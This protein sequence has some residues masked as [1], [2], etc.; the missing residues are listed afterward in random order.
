MKK[1]AIAS[2]AVLA[3][4]ILSGCVGQQPA[5]TPTATPAATTAAA[6]TAAATTAAATTPAATTAAATTAAP[7][8]AYSTSDCTLLNADDIKGVLGFDVKEITD[9]PSATYKTESGCTKTW[10]I[11]SKP[12]LTVWIKVTDT[13]KDRLYGGQTQLS[14]TNTCKDKTS[15]GLGDYDSC[16]AS[17]TTM[18]GKGNYLMQISCYMVCSQEQY[19]QLARIMLGRM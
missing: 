13:T 3:I 17:T 1:I 19:N 14:L 4:V 18:F 8:A 2:F 10:D 9:N 15:L 11:P 16:E 7:A 12:G 6:T 5:G